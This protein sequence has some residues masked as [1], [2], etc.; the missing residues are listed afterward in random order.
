MEIQ[1]NL[2]DKINAYVCEITVNGDYALHIEREKPGIF[3]MEQRSSSSGKYAKCHIPEQIKNS[4]RLVLDYVFSHG[5]Y[6]MNL[7]LISQVPVTK[8]E[9]NEISE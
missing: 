5:Y 9:L 3:V 2:E 8:A 7:R 4:E 6:P 1:F